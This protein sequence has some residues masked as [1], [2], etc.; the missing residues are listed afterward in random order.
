MKCNNTE[1]VT[2]SQQAT[3]VYTDAMQQLA[4]MVTI[5]QTKP[6]IL[7][8]KKLYVAVLLLLSVFEI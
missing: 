8:L 2:D 7:K 1:N 6:L 4:L 5:L 3:D